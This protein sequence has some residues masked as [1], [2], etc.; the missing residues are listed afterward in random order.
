MQ[1]GLDHSRCR[2][3]KI[4]FSDD[5]RYGFGQTVHFTENMLE[6]WA[7]FRNASLFVILFVRAI[8]GGFVRNFG[9]VRNSVEV[10]LLEYQEEIHHFAGWEGGV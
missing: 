5:F 6:I 1:N 7:K 8:F 3:R 4:Q 9:C 10:L 2:C